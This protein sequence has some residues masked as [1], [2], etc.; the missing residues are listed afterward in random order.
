MTQLQ[1]TFSKIREAKQEQKRLRAVYRDL[2]KQNPEYERTVDEIKRLREQKRALED[3][4]K[5]EMGKD[6]EKLEDLAADI[7]ADSELLG[8]LSITEYAK[9]ETVSVKD[10]MDNEYEPLFSVR[11]VK[12]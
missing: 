6:Y 5:Q 11:F 10:E 8:D 3:G 1:E 2:L 9:G 12:K 7:K 4:A